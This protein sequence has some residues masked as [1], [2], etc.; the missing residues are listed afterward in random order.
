MQKFFRSRLLG[1]IALCFLLFPALVTAQSVSGELVGTIYDATGAIVAGA[2]VIATNVGTGVQTSTVSSS[3]GQY[4]LGNL[5]A[6]SYDLKVTAKGFSVAEIKGVSVNLNMQSTSNVTLQIGESKTVVEVTGSS[7]TIDTTTAQVESTFD[8]K[9]LAD[10][11]TTS[12]GSGVLNL[13][14]YTSGVSTSGAIGAGTGPSVGGQRPRNNNFTIE[15]I[16]N[17]SKSV[18]G[19]LASIPNDAVQEFSILANQ[20]SAQYGHSSGGQFNQVLKGGTNEFHGMAYEYLKN[21]NLDALDQQDIVSGVYSLPRYDN[22]R[23]GGNIGGPIKKNKLFFFFDYEYNPVGASGVPGAIYAPTTDGYATLAGIPGINQTNLGVLKQYLPGQSTAIPGAS[24]TICPGTQLGLTNGACPAGATQYQVPYGQYS[25]TAPSYTNYYTYVLSADYTI[26]D[27]DQL[28][29]RYIRNN[30]T[31]QDT[32]AQLPEFWVPEIFP[33]YLA[34][35]TEFHNFSPNLTNEF[36]LG[37]NRYSQVY[38]V[39]N[40][41]FPGLDQFPNLQIFDLNGVQIGADPNAPQETI[42]NL[43]QL[44]DNVSW[45]K[46]AHTVTAGADFK[47]FISPQTFTQRGRGDY[48]YSFLSDY[49]FDYIPD[50]LGERTTGNFVYYGDQIQFGAYV[51]D[52]WKVKPNFTIN[53]GVRYERTTLP[54]GERLQNVNAISN[55]PGLISFGT[56]TPQNLNFEPRVG[57]AYSPGTSGKTSIRGGFG[58]NYDQLFDNLGILSAAPQFQQTVDVGGN[59]GSGFL[60]GGGILP[61]ASSGTLDQADARANTGGYIPNQKL[62]KSLQWNIGIQR[63]VH[64]DYTLELRYLGTR[65]LNLPIQDRLDIQAVVNAQNALPMY[66]TMPS[67]ATLDGLTNTLAALTSTYDAGGR[68]LPQYL[69]AGFQSNI[70][71]FMPMGAS[72]YHGLASQVT[73]RFH[74][75]LQFVGAYTFSHNIDNSTAEVFS[76]Y[77]TPRRVQDF[78][79]LNADRS[80]SALDHRNRFTLATVYDMPFFKN[81]NWFMKNLVGNWE[82]APIYTY[83]T[84]TLYTIQSGIDSNMNGDSAGDRTWINP[85]GT[86][87]IGSAATALTNSNGDTVAFLAN[88]PQARYV[89]APKGVLTTGGRNTAH[90]HPIDNI[91]FSLLKR[92]NVSKEGVRKLEFGARFYNF[93]NHPQYSGSNINDVA[94]VGYTGGPVHDFLIPG[95]ANFYDPTAVFSSNP[96]S[97]QLSAK[98]I[99]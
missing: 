58:I 53:L 55:V 74:N 22:N 54:Y 95:Q 15:G 42:Q 18:T 81:S 44:T 2:S 25:F 88:N 73:R 51:N 89:Q 67:Q 92:F 1:V 50:Y 52:S 96:R 36:R 48:E 31:T 27:K 56:P 90:L 59:A 5:P 45:L 34:T 77:T 82:L 80:S 7:V 91:D 97:I 71:A 40:Q 98:F 94:S 35:L 99:F 83:E 75:G 79:N 60:A 3:A 9:Q 64:E 4:R 85:Q 62:P 65:G 69:N 72:T 38:P 84:G 19:P 41:K 46:G 21:R 68:F 26:S 23:F 11:P 63:V 87:N 28:R 66:T 17:N 61:N 43:Y 37:F 86:V 12:G 49:L 13:A 93:L 76:T 6:G 47:K 29:G 78:Q 20:F 57:F 16:D 33:N 70:V 30:E 32:S 10:L 8:A 14:L 24:V 39:G